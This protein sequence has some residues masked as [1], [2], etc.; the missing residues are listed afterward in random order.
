MKNPQK[1]VVKTRMWQERFRKIKERNERYL[2]RNRR[3]TMTSS[4]HP[5]MDHYRFKQLT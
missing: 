3:S 1:K 5:S 2:S 4:T